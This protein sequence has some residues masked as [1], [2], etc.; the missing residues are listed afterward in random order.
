MR[1][2]YLSGTLILFAVNIQLCNRHS[3][4]ATDY[5]R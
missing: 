5:K 4:Q 2:S 3:K 1:V